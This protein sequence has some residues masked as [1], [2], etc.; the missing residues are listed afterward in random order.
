M[1][2]RIEPLPLIMP[3]E[4]SIKFIAMSSAM[5]QPCTK[6]VMTAFEKAI[7][8][9]ALWFVKYFILLRRKTPLRRNQY[10]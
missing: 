4:Q 1:D 3:R 6:A 8:H 2:Y 7:L 9:R 5:F 10:P